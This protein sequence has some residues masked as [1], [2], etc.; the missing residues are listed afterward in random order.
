MEKLAVC[1]SQIAFKTHFTAFGLTV[2]TVHRLAWIFAQEACYLFLCLIVCCF[3]KQ[4]YT[5]MQ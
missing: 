4:I 3:V 2:T 5:I 1:L